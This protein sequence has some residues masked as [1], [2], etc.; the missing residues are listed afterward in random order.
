MTSHRA[1]LRRADVI[2]RVAADAGVPTGDTALVL[3]ALLTLIETELRAG[4]EVALS[5]FGRFHV[6]RRGGRRAANPRTGE[7]IDV[8]DVNTPRFTP[9]AV[10]KRAARG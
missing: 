6:A 10:L 4:G 9:G 5:G 8:P 2:E 3:D 7:A 1:A